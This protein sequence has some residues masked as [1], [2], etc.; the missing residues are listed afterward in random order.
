MAGD[1]AGS[2]FEF[3][4][5]KTRDFD[6]V[7]DGCFWTDDTVLTAAVGLAIAQNRDMAKTLRFCTLEWI[8]S[9]GP[10]YWDW[11]N[12]RLG[13]GPYGSWGNGSSMRVS[14]A[15]WL[16]RDVAEC[17]RLARASAQVTHD[18][19]EGIR[20]AEAVALA[21]YAGL[22]GWPRPAIRALV[23]RVSGYDL[24]GT[25][26][27]IRS[28]AEFELKSWISVPRALV[29]A[30]EADTVEDAIRNAVSLGGDADTE[31]AIAASISETWSEVPPDLKAA[32]LRQLPED[33]R[34]LYLRLAER[35]AAVKRRPLSREEA[36]GLLT[37][38]PACV[39]RWLEARKPRADE[40][41]EIAVSHWLGVEQA[42][43][44]QAPSV[45]PR[46]GPLS[47]LLGAFGLR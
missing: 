30:F 21:I 41:T 14:P 26:D 16:A 44:S 40:A 47:R 17:M 22:S 3:K 43:H 36:A 13:D 46:P 42:I 18:H 12:G 15:A 20:G 34:E 25:V 11:A 35:A 9:Y 38:D 1:F 45:F 10:H 24:S 19:P 23:A 32:A 4:P 6:L 27:G 2:R 37:W 7:S 31:A 28:T 8:A 5:I 29:C 33:L 39:A